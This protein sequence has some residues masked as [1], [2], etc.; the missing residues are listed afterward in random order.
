MK[1]RFVKS[2]KRIEPDSDARPRLSTVREIMLLPTDD[3]VTYTVQVLASAYFLLAEHYTGSPE[4][5]FSCHVLN[6]CADEIA[7]GARYIYGGLNP[8]PGFTETTSR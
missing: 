5:K 8:S 1:G 6:F 3:D 2:A 4:S 7:S